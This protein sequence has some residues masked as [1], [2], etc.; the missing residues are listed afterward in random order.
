MATPTIIMPARGERAAPLFDKSRPREITRFFNDLEILFGRAQIASEADKKK[1]VVYYTDF[2]TE[3]IWKS[4]TEFTNA[5]STYQNFKDAIL[6]Y[7]PDASGDYVYSIRDVDTLI[8]ERQRL[9]INSTGDLTD[10]HLH[11]LAITT[12]LI[13]KGQFSDLEQKRS[14]LRA[15]QPSLLAAINSRLQTQFPTQHPNVPN[16]IKEVFDAANYILQSSSASQQYIASAPAIPPI[17]I[18]Q[19]PTI[20]IAAPATPTPT[21]KTENLGA[22]FSEFTKT[23]VEAMNKNLRG[24][25][26]NPQQAS[27]SYSQKTCIMCGLL[28]LINQCGIVEE[29][30]TAGKCK[31]NHEGRVVLPSGSFVP[32]DILPDALLMERINEYHRR[33][34]NQLAAAT[35]IH[36]IARETVSRSA[37]AIVQPVYQLST[38]DRIATLEAELFNLKARRPQVPAAGVRTRN[39]RAREQEE[40]VVEEI[41]APAARQKTPEVSVPA[42][43]KVGV[44]A[45]PPVIVAER[46][47]RVQEEP[48]HPYQKARDA[49]YAPPVNRNVGAAAKPIAPNRAEPAYKTLPPVHDPNIA[50]EVYKRSMEAPITITQ[51]ELLSLAPEVR[52]QVREVTTTRRVATEKPAHTF[53]VE[54]DEDTVGTN[55]SAFAYQHASHRTPPEG[56]TII[57][58]PIEA[59]Y[60]SLK[61]G[62]QPDLDHLTVAKE[63]TAIRS[64]YS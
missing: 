64:L 40:E 4:F 47:P 58:D 11:F 1:Y 15:F 56:S 18:L 25:S 39:Q 50:A 28:H 19:R 16:K 46:G 44:P 61:P 22:L 3:Q 30:I 62:Q 59:Y 57:P 36:T 55:A 17:T 60:K 38:N 5:L 6:E 12:W 13:N 54:E 53:V 29:Y 37:D 14:Y 45:E 31:R 34:P 27:S 49:A 23:I 8:G 63:S 9:G 2:E 26:N 41:V 42:V 51:R 48:E 20:P 52:S 33:F 21:V 10:F 35:L 43:P 32:R 7:Y 24:P